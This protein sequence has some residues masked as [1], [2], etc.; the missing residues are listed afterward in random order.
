MAINVQTPPHAYTTDGWLVRIK[1]CFQHK[2][3]YITPLG[4]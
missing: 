2:L 1:W 3:G 4:L